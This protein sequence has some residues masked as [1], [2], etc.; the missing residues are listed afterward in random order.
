MVSADLGRL[1]MGHDDGD[2]HENEDESAASSAHAME[3]QYFALARDMHEVLVSPLHD[4]AA[5]NNVLELRRAL[6]DAANGVNTQDNAG[7]TPAHWAAGAGA[8]DTLAYLLELECDLTLKNLLGDTPLHR[9][10]WRS[11]LLAVQM[12][13]DRGRIDLDARN[14][15]QMLAIDLARDPRVRAAL[16]CLVP[17]DQVPEIMRVNPEDFENSDDDDDDGLDEIER[18]KLAGF[19]FADADDDDGDDDDDDDDDDAGVD[20]M[21]VVGE[22]GERVEIMHVGR[23]ETPAPPR[24]PPPPVPSR[25]NRPPLSRPRD[26][27]DDGMPQLE[28]IAEQPSSNFEDAD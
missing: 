1:L 10:A 12:L 13:V 17:T 5:R 27:D 7:N 19:S 28:P 6:A 15:D 18:A 22:V 4:A 26:E 9:A 23:R 20:T 21:I 16:S 8:L 2:E 25:H 14:N 11:Q 3:K 24:G